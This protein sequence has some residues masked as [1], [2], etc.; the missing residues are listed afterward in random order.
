MPAYQHPQIVIDIAMALCKDP[1]FSQRRTTN[2]NIDQ[3]LTDHWTTATR[4]DLFNAGM[5]SAQVC[6]YLLGNEPPPAGIT[7]DQ[8]RLF[9]V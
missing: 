3:A 5:L 9:T 1:A 7:P 2:E 4:R 8:L 6:G